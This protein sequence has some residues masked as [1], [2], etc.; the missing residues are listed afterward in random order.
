MLIRPDRDDLQVIGFYL[1]KVMVGVGYVLGAPMLVAAVMGDW[2]DLTAFLL[3]AGLSISIGRLAERRF[4][5]TQQLDWSHGLVTAALSWLLGA[6]LFAVPLDLSGHY[7]SYVDAYFE[8]MSG[9][10]ATGL[11]LTQDIDH[12]SVSVNLLRHITHFLGGQGII[13]VMLT[14]LGSSSGQVST[15]YVGEGRDD[16]I[17]P[18]VV[19]TARFIYL[20]ASVYLVVG[21]IALT[22]AGLVAGF[23]PLR[24][25]IHGLNLF[26]A[27][28]DTG[29]FATNST[30]I[31]YYHSA[32]IE[33]VLIV[34][35]VAGALSFLLHYELW[36]GRRREV[37]ENLEVR[38]IAVTG[39][40]T[41]S[42]LLLGLARAGTFTDVGSLFRKGVFSAI[43]AH[44]ST[45]FT[46]NASRMF[47]TDWG[48]IAPAALLMALA[49]GGMA[50]S[51]AGGVK[52]IRVGLAAKSVS[53]DVRRAIQPDAA[54]V[55]VTYTQRHRRRITDAPVR[56]AITIL[57]LYVLLFLS[58]ALVGVY[59]GVPFEQALFESTS[60][61]VN[62][63]MSVGVLEPGTP[64]PMK[65]TYTAQMWLGRLEFMA[66][67]ALLGYGIALVRGRI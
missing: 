22:L 4:A 10:T 65:L 30:S 9:L 28:F 20:V 26:M 5:T 18:N 32:A 59:Y 56:S 50:S 14:G 48:R 25:V 35:M 47:V 2:D 16:R 27:A 66:V 17:L 57:V 54:V 6:A 7:G 19:R 62:G 52:G 12:M 63:G 40:I 44:T 37:L 24:S 8:A 61:S 1:G 43:S 21:T 46:V 55:A 42:L 36:R 33:G 38:T 11:T 31:S 3:G 39:L 15:L 29:G 67:F 53:R 58:G 49:L 45:G 64:L 60:A 51:T 13:I 34:L 41:T 23:S